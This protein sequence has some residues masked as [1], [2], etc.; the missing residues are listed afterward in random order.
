MLRWDG[1][2][3]MLHVDDPDGSGLVLLEEHQAAAGETGG[4]GSA[5]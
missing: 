5:T 1:V 3:P 2:P 4:S